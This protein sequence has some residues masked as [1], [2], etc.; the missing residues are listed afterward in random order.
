MPEVVEVQQADEPGRRKGRLKGRRR[1]RGWRGR[2]GDGVPAKPRSSRGGG[3]CDDAEGGDGD[4]GR[5]SGEA[6]G[7][8][9]D[10][11]VVATPLVVG[12]DA[13]PVISPRNGGE[14]GKEE[15]AATPGEVAA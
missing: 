9:G 10:G 13:S 1:R 8:A 6:A 4:V 14:A 5:R 2:R 15:A 11:G 7:M 3:R 12:E